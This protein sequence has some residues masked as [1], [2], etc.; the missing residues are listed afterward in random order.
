MYWTIDLDIE[1]IH[2]LDDSE[3]IV[4]D[5]YP[6]VENLR[7]KD[8]SMRL[9]PNLGMK[10]MLTTLAHEMVHIKQFARDEMYEYSRGDMTRWRGK[11]IN[12]HSYKYNKLPW[13]IE[14]NKLESI[15]YE[16]WI[17]HKTKNV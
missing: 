3:G 5:V 16:E 7:P 11:K 13:E 17:N 6:C 4:G 9:C 14:A 8:F 10:L 12:A 1:I 15:L 2:R